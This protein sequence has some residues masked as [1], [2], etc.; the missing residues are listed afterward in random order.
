MGDDS[1]AAAVDCEGRPLAA[2][3]VAVA[4]SPPPCCAA[5][6]GFDDGV[7]VPRLSLVAISN[8]CPAA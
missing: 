5:I 6:P 3:A 2:D 7:A 8:G 4:A 1:D